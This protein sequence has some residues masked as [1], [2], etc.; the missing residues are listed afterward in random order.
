MQGCLQLG[1]LVCSRRYVAPEIPIS[2]SANK[3]TTSR[4]PIAASIVPLCGRF[5]QSASQ[6]IPQAVSNV[7][8]PR[9][10]PLQGGK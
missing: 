8:G 7:P 3:T 4:Y 5:M 6:R 9:S 2:N 10:E 1:L